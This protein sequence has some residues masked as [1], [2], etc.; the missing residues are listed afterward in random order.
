MGPGQDEVASILASMGDGD[1]GAISRLLPHVYEELRAAARSQMRGETVAHTLQPTALAHEAF[2][3]LMNDR[4]TCK[5][6]AEFCRLA[7]FEMRRV[8]IDH[9]RKRHRLKRGGGNRGVSLAEGAVAAPEDRER[10]AEVHE[11]LAKLAAIDERAAQV[12][13]LRFYF[14]MGV[15]ETA[16][17]LGV[18]E[19]T[20]VFDRRFAYA[21]LKR[22]LARK[23][24]GG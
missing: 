18:S 22:E 17:L 21:W 5:D 6:R 23:E 7:A 15:K 16:G 1:L 10:Y 9:A 24:S 4:V 11:A 2:L 8:L 12:A 19:R 20:V 14:D 3:R 13:E